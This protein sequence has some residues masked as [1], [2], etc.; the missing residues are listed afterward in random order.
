MSQLSDGFT[1]DQDF[2]ALGA[3]LIAGV[4]LGGAGG[5]L[6]VSQ[7]SADLVSG[8]GDGLTLLQDL[9]ALS[10]DLI[11]GVTFGSA[12][13][14]LDVCQGSACLVPLSDGSVEGVTLELQDFLGRHG[15]R[16]DFGV[17]QDHVNLEIDGI[18]VFIFIL[19][20]IDFEGGVIVSRQIQFVTLQ[21]VD[22]EQ[23][24]SLVS[25]PTLEIG[26]IGQIEFEFKTGNVLGVFQETHGAL[27]LVGQ[28]G[29]GVG[30]FA[31]GIID[32]DF[33]LTAVSNGIMLDIGA[34]VGEVRI[35]E[36]VLVHGDLF[37]LGLELYI[38]FGD[39][40]LQSFFG[41]VE[42]VGHFVDE[43]IV[44]VEQPAFEGV[45]GTG[46]VGIGVTAGAALLCESFVVFFAGAASEVHKD[47]AVCH[48]AVGSI[49]VIGYGELTAHG[50]EVHIGVVIGIL[51][52]PNGHELDEVILGGII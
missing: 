38:A 22:D 37:P 23:S 9:T 30:V 40:E 25:G 52:S 35:T 33:E 27:T 14:G 24:F 13:S 50:V 8:L 11:A 49:D 28:E 19:F 4:T 41:G 39:G 3:D 17:F 10:A 5:G 46:G 51:T 42:L 1:L 29:H 12:G 6:D 34:I 7:G 45:A 26:L 2:A 16:V 15:S 18:T 43:Q 36:T 31:A 47:L 20:S 48:R 32:A 21:K 44:G